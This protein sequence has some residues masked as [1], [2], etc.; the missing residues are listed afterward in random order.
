MKHISI[1]FFLFIFSFF[2]S[3]TIPFGY[4]TTLNGKQTAALKTE[5]HKILMKDTTRYLSYGSGFN[6]TWQGFYATDRNTANNLVV[7]MYSNTLRYYSTDYVG[8]NYPGFGQELHIEHSLP[9][10]WWGSYEWAAYKDLHHLYP[11]DGS[12]NLSKSNNPLGVVTGTPTKDNGLSKSGPGAYN[13]YVGNVF[14]PADQ[15][16]GDFARSYFYMATAY[17]H[18]VNL[19]NIT[20]PENMMEKNTYPVFKTWAKE[21][22]LQWHRQDT[23]SEKER[24]RMEKVY[25]IQG[26]RNPFIDYP[27]LVEYIWGNSTDFPWNVSTA[28]QPLENPLLTIK[29]NVT[30]FTVESDE[31]I[32]IGVAIYAIDGKQ[33]LSCK[34]STN[35][36]INLPKTASGIVFFEISSSNFV[37][38][39][40]QM[41][42]TH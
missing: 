27:E 4:Y 2:V 34:S 8:L 36:E 16:K 1:F 29:R 42:T 37:I 17:E 11:A 19:W 3:A 9:K 25:S 12:M 15:Y 32:P 40:K 41:I 24:S 33:I 23:V 39:Q 14:E 6:R 22:L 26:N 30:G 35:T 13:G 7:D 31:T 21:L 10:S 18:Y 5:L 28:N 20:A 38:R